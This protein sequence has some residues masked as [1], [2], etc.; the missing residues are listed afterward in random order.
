LEVDVKAKNR[1]PKI[2]VVCFTGNSGLTDYSVSLCRELAKK[3]NVVFITSDSYDTVKYRISIPTIKIFRRT[4]QYPID[5]IYFVW[6]VLRHKPDVVLFQS[7]LKY[8]LLEGWIV[9]LFNLCGIRTALT[10]HDLLPHYPKQWSKLL[11][12]WYYRCFT[13]L[14]VHSQRSAN[15]LNEMAVYSK[16]LVVPHGV[17]DIFRMNELTRIDVMP[18]FP[19]IQEDDFVVLYFGHIE[20]RKGILEFLAASDLLSAKKIKFLIA[21]RNDLGSSTSLARK[22]DAYRKHNNVVIHDHSIAFEDVQRY[23][24]VA[25]VV[26]LPYL[27]GTTSG[28]IKLAMAFDKP[29]IAANVGDLAETLQD[30]SG[31]LLEKDNLSENLAVAINQ[32]IDSYDSYLSSIA[33]NKSKYSWSVIGEKYFSWIL[34][35]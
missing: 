25:D 23:F 22:F 8:P 21:G 6:Y 31:I 11:H 2:Y 18:L 28:V 9:K 12:A 33:R 1:I 32:L 13:E 14:I 35:N 10:I 3:G 26:A 20:I 15:G 30:W 29:V 4:R 27:E 34:G 17:Y 5:V 16:P 24:I 7:W 19:E